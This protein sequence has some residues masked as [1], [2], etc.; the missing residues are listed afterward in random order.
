MEISR[1][2]A[3]SPVEVF[4]E[5][6][7]YLLRICV[8]MMPRIAFAMALLLVLSL[9][10]RAQVSVTMQH[11]DVGRTGQNTSETSL[12]PSNVNSTQ[13][14]RLFIAPVD[15]QIYAQP[16]YMPNVAIPGQG[17]HNVVYVATEHDSVYAFDADTGGAALWHVTFLINGATSVNW[18][19]VNAKDIYPEIGITGTP[20]IDPTTNTLYVVVETYENSAP[21]HRLH[22]LDITTGAEKFN[23]PVVIAASGPGTGDGSSGGVMTF[24]SVL[25]NQRPGLLLLNGFVYIGFAA[26]GD[27]GN[28]H[29]WILSYNAATLQQ[30]GAFDASP[31]GVG[32]GFWAAGSG[33]SADNLNGGRLFVATGNGDFPVLGNVAPNPAPAPSTSV[34]YGDSIIQLSITNGAIAPTDYFTPYNTASLDGADTDLGAGGVLIPPDQT[35]TYPHELIQVGKQGHIYVLNRDQFTN[36]NSHFCSGCSSDPE[37]LQ[38]VTG[39]TGLWSMPAYWNGNVYFWGNG[40]SLKAYT[41]TGGVLSASPTSQSAETSG[42]PGS[43]PVVSANGTTNGIVWA[44]E[45]DGYLNSPA[46]L[47]AYN[48]LNVSQLLYGS[49]LTS[50]RDTLGQAVKFTLPVVANGKVYVGTYNQL[51]AF[52]LF[53]S[54]PTVATPTFTPAPGASTTAVTVTLSDAT[55][56][57]TIYYTTNGAT[58]TTSSAVYSTGIPVTSSTTINAIAVAKGYLNSPVATGVYTIAGQTAPPVISPAGGSYTS[59]QPVTITDASPT[60]TIYYTTNGT[61]PTHSSAV[62][63]SAISVASTETITA[64][65]SSPGLVDSAPVSAAYTITAATGGSINYGLGFASD[66]GMQL[67]GSA[68]L[69]DSR[70]QLTNGGTNEASSAFYTTPIDIRNFTTDFTIQISDAVADGMTF[71]IQNSAAGAGA[72]G[73]DGGNLGYGGGTSG[74]G[75]SIAI[76]FDIY[77]NSGEG[78]DSTGLYQNGAAP[79][80]PSIDMTSSGVILLSGDTIA[81]HMVYNGTTLTMTLTDAIVNKTFT[82]AWTV[83]IPSIVGG[84]LAYIGFTGGSGGGSSSQKVES[85]TLTSTPPAAPAA[86]TPVI[87]PAAQTFSGTLSVSLSDTTTGASIYYTTD[88]SIPSPGVGTTLLYSTAFTVSATTTVNAIATATNYSTSPTATTVFTQQ[89]AAAPLITPATESFNGTVSVSMTDSTTGALIYYTTDGSAPSPGVG[90]TKQYS[91]AFAVI[92][93]TTVKAIATASGFSSSPT[94]TATYT[95]QTVATPAISPAPG[96]YSSSVT[97]TITDATSG[98]VIYY[99]TDGST[100]SPGVGTTKAYAAGGFSLTASATVKAIATA[101]GYSASATASSTYTI[102]AASGGISAYSSGFTS[103]AGLQLNGSASWLQASKALALTTST[104]QA[105]SFFATTPVNVQSFTNNFSFQLPAPLSDGLTFVIQ[106]N[107]AT[108]LG[109]SGGALGYS[110][111]S[112]MTAPFSKSVAIKFDV[113]NNNGEGTDSTGVYLN[114]APPIV[115]AVD[116][117]SSGLNLKSGHVFN[118]TMMYDGTWLAMTITDATTSQSFTD[119]WQVNIPA[120]VGGSTAYVGFTAGTGG[121]ASTQEILTWS[122]A[123]DAPALVDATQFVA[124]NLMASSK[125]SGP[126]YQVIAWPEFATGNGTCLYATKVGDNITINVSVPAAGTYDVRFSTKLHAQRGIGQL[127]VDGV[128]IGKPTDQYAAVDA[129]SEIDLGNVTL[130]AGSHVFKLAVTGENAASSGYYLAIDTIKL[131]P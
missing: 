118:V 1:M 19:V 99:T 60:P 106:G 17:T 9:Q 10:A 127:S 43:T 13:F 21:I 49:N 44:V 72:L 111:V 64:I 124:A 42:F 77:S 15:G 58:P 11:Y 55:S 29:G 53:G 41:F 119:Q 94:A 82:Q 102:Q 33:L 69:D 24:S 88:G 50:G 16:L 105:G 95:Q 63:S 67:N 81:A 27:N 112:S 125:S 122:Y 31:N 123:P 117:T 54:S 129:W 12:T 114:G 34:D 84:N 74:I 131:L 98:A 121:T 8:R 39:I 68:D 40:D 92:A 28:W 90:T 3:Q 65:A 5:I 48:A 70:L 30:A 59:T 35:G 78:T 7:S 86:A 66:G 36:N 2:P 23:G 25:E 37:I 100:P 115:P 26:N 6:P 20:V 62:Y 101:S 56:G 91:S 76:K 107:S 103:T 109:G 52:G 57:A 85:W 120:A 116:M 79:I 75:K 126:S 18:S 87:S 45:S 22:A 113:Y 73:L 96:T 128:N 97:A 83:N 47:R 14:G 89:A 110:V 93:T 130:T 51:D 80:L 71:T 4:P 104:S 38:T 32:S 108:G 61:T 46:I